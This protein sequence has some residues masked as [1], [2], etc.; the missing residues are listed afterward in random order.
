MKCS[1]LVRNPSRKNEGTGPRGSKRIKIVVRFAQRRVSSGKGK[2][3]EKV[4]VSGIFDPIHESTSEVTSGSGGGARGRMGT[5]VNICST[6]E[7]KPLLPSRRRSKVRERMFADWER[8]WTEQ[9]RRRWSL[10][11]LRPISAEGRAMV[12]SSMVW[13]EQAWRL[14]LGVILLRVDT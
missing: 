13:T 4:I 7:I 12:V 2:G 3:G 14:W 11:F 1:A 8:C 5:K 6:R 9:E 10:P